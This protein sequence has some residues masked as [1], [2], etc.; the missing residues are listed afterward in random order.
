MLFMDTLI[1]RYRERICR[2]AESYGA[3]NVRLFGSRAREQASPHSDIDLLVD[4]D[5][6]RSL[7]DLIALEET[8]TELLGAKVDLVT[9]SSVSRYLRAEIEREAIAL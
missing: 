2:I 9:P 4:M 3:R 7:L 5:K 8:L 1:D 6:G